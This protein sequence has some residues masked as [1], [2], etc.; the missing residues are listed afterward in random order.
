MRALLILVFVA[1]T[2]SA[3]KPIPWTMKGCVLDGVFYD[4]DKDGASRVKVLGMQLDLSKLEGKR[5]ELAGLLYPGDRFKA[6]A[7]PPV[8]VRDCNAEEKRH[9]E[10][11]KAHDLRMQAGRAADA[12]K[13]EEALKLVIASISLVQPADCD[14]YI[15]RAH[16]YVKRDD[17][18]AATKD[19]TIL[20][21]RK[22]RFRGALNFLLLQELAADLRAKEAH[23]IA[24]DVLV[25][26]L[27]GC[28][29]SDICKPDLERELAEARKAA[30]KK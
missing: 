21:T 7:K 30:A 6:G 4:I 11:T 22:C 2:A 12:G 10:Y 9:V 3:S 19:V 25:M 16:I 18:P 8:V 26:A 13:L 20:K 28:G 17:L 15:D 14:T 1:G 5:I 27:E 24:V 23:R 29:N